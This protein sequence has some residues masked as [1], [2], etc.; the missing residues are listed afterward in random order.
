MPVHHW[1]RLL[2]FPVRTGS[3]CTARPDARYPRFRR[4]LFVRDR[5]FDHDGATLPRIPAMHVLPSTLFTASASACFF[6][7]RLNNLPHTIVVYASQ[8]SSPST[9]QH[10]LPSGRYPLL[11]PDFHR[12]EHASL[13]WRTNRKP[14]QGRGVRPGGHF[15]RGDRPPMLMVV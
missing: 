2:A 12:L 10:S 7:S 9:T 11:G 5:V 15:A 4:V 14:T 6:L 13:A 8:W 1:L 3:V